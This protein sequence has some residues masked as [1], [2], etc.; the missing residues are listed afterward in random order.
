MGGEAQSA[1]TV[2]RRHELAVQLAQRGDLAQARQRLG[3]HRFRLD[4][5]VDILLDEP[6]Q[7][8]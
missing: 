5:V 1:A 8:V 3:H 6:S 4:H 7:L 2:V